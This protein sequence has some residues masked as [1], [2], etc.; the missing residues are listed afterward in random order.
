MNTPNSPH[1]GTASI[2]IDLGGT[3]TEAILLSANGIVLWRQRRPT[4]RSD[5]YAA[6]LSIVAE[7][8]REA[9]DQLPPDT[10]YTVNGGDGSV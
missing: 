8:T 10:H 7:I 9:A 3:K 1:S 2:S 5:G 4:K 6:V